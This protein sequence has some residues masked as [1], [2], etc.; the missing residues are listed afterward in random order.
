MPF[1]INAIIAFLSSAF[2]VLIAFLIKFFTKKVAVR[3]AAGVLFMGLL[4]AFMAAVTAIIVTLT[5]SLPPEVV[6]VAG[7][8]VPSNAS[9]CVSAYYSAVVAR[10]VYDLRIDAM[11]VSSYIT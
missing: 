2:T 10:W 3:I 5:Y 8:V 1:F 4:V 7:W 9:I 11:R 6:L